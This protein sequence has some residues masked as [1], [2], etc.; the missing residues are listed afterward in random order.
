MYRQ[1]FEDEVFVG[2]ISWRVVQTEPEIR[3]MADQTKGSD[4]N[5]VCQIDGPKEER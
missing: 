4:T 2:G 1:E 5:A 3:L